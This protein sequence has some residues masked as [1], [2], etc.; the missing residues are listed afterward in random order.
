MAKERMQEHPST[1]PPQNKLAAWL[2]R[3]KLTGY[4]AAP[5]L[6][7]SQ[8]QVY[9]LAAGTSPVM[10]TLARLLELLDK[11]GIPPEWR[12][13]GPPRYVCR[14]A[15]IGIFDCALVLRGGCATAKLLQCSP[16]W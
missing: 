14:A 1:G 8:Q 7:L 5:I 15:Q 4:K 6:G 13:R 3:H 16:T 10:P 2:E 12:A 11:H 9:K